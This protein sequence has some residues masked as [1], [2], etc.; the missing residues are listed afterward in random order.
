[1]SDKKLF[2]PNQL[3]IVQEICTIHGL[4]P[5]QIS[6]EGDEL[7]PIFDY[8]AGSALTLKLTD[9]HDIDCWISGR[10][11]APELATAKCKITLLDGRTRTVEDTAEMG[12]ELYKGVK[13]DSP[14]MIDN[15]AKNRA[16]RR[17]V[18]SVGVNL[19]NAHKKFR[20]TGEIANAH[21]AH[22]PRYANYREIHVLATETGLI[23]DGDKKEYRKFIAGCFNGV[24]SSKDLNDIELHQLVAALRAMASH[25]RQQQRKSA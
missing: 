3:A 13:I 10:E 19:Y 21:T 6:F 8:E 14:R 20:E 5:E 17:G 2:T 1:M 25:Q 12:E 7:T 24:E 22:D 15:V 4:E 11:K 23:D 18:R 16:F 9:I